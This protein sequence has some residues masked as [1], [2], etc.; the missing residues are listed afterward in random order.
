MDFLRL[1]ILVSVAMFALSACIAPARIIRDATQQQQSVSRGIADAIDAADRAFGEPRIEDR[2]RIVQIK[3]GL[4]P[5]YWK[6][7]EFTFKVPIRTRIPIPAIERRINLFFQF[8][9]ESDENDTVTETFS[10]LDQNKSFAA[11]LLT[12]I[13]KQVDV[14]TRFGVFWSDGLQSAVRPFLRWEYQP[15]QTRYYIEQE[16]YY[17]TDDRFGGRTVGSIDHVLQDQ[18]VNRYQLAVEYSQVLNGILFGPTYIHR[19]PLPFD[20]MA[21]TEVGI[22]FN[23]YHGASEGAG[24]LDED[25]SDHGLVRFRFA[26]K[27][28]ISWLEYDVETGAD[29]Y[30]LHE[31]PWDY[32]ILVTARI[33]FESYLRTP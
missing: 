28:G 14:G 27:T 1:L 4:Q 11:T 29:Y 32:G 17:R 16:V 5:G 33:I 10:N 19:R 18:A 8:D 31:D 21:S 13:S 20:A 15:A 2:E 7:D 3:V 22:R 24:G 9:S 12:E 25:D 6:Q 23:P 26:G 30:W